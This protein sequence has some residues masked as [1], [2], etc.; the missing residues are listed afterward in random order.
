MEARETEPRFLLT[1]GK[2]HN[3]LLVLTVLAACEAAAARAQAEWRVVTRY[4]DARYQTDAQTP[5]VNVPTV[6]I[7]GER[8]PVL[9]S[10]PVVRIF[11]HAFPPPVSRRVTLDVPVPEHLRGRPLRLTSSVPDGGAAITGQTPR[12]VWKPDATVKLQVDLSREIDK[13]VVVAVATRAGPPETS[14]ESAPFSVPRGARLRFGIGVD[15]SEWTPTLAAVRFTLSA[16]TDGGETA[17]FSRRLDPA[18]RPEHRK[19]FDHA[20]DLTPYSG[21]TIRLRFATE[22]KPKESSA[23]FLFPVWSDPTLLA[24][25][26]EGSHPRHVLLVSLDT[27][28]PDHL[29]SYGYRRPTSPNIDALLAARGTV[30]ERAFATSPWTLP[31]HAAMLTGLYSC[32]QRLVPPGPKDPEGG[33]I[34]SLSPDAVTL[35]EGLRMHGYTTAAF[36]EDGWISAEMGF[37]RGFGT[38]IENRA[39]PHLSEPLGQVERTTHD[40]LAWIR[41]HG[42]V[43]WFVFVHTYQIHNPYTPPPGYMELVAPDHGDDR[44][45]AD[46][47][48][49]DAEIRYTDDVLAQFLAGL[50]AAGAG[51]ALVALVSDHGEGFNE[52]GLYMHGNSLYEELLHVVFMLRAPGLVPAGRRISS[53]VGLIDLVPTLLEL[54][55]LL[56][57]RRAEGRSLA[58]LLR[59]DDGPDPPPL[60]ADLGGKVAVRHAGLK[61]IIDE[62]T[63]AAEV[64]DLAADPRETKS[65]VGTRTLPRE[66][67]AW[68]EDF[69]KICPPAGAP[70]APLGGDTVD[71]TVRQKL[72]ALGYVE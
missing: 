42:D 15:E 50:D 70:A 54:V 59:Q 7:A 31:S 4:V 60:F 38:L 36:T 34:A 61:W 55:D 41:R 28:R 12:V 64:F 63:A 71:P 66:P 53:D 16:L 65:V 19:W 69:H 46:A 18:V 27:L 11:H 43:P 3:A 44:A 48:A 23:P 1:V 51:D 10:S 32:A 56:A 30:F 25:A 49:Y 33:V 2:T 62:K 14:Y 6:E 58:S 72:R 9:A 47:A 29:G 13:G 35:A 68:L 22:A 57:P 40:A 45:E 20:V 17:L 21:Q 39:F 8:R 37:A 67:A 26:A 52:H 5:P 24:P